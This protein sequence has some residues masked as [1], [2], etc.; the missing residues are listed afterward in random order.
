[1]KA[2]L[3]TFS[4]LQYLCWCFCRVIH[5]TT[6]Q[7]SMLQFQTLFQ[8]LALDL[9]TLSFPKVWVAS[10]LDGRGEDQTFA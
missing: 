9:V 7:I 4:E 5:T 10:L 1:V 6:E 8:Q 3:A 2:T